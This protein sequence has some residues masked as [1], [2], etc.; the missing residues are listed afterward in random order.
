MHVLIA[1]DKFKDALSAEKVCE[2]IEK[3]IRKADPAFKTTVFPMADG[4]NGT[5]D[6]L[7]YHSKGKII[8]HEVHDPLGRIIKSRLGVS[9]D[10]K[11]AF[12]E[13]AAASGLELLKPAER[14]CVNTSTFGT[15]ELIV[16]AIALGVSRI[17]IGIGG[18]ATN[19]GGTGMAAALGYRFR[20]A[21]GE[22]LEP[23]GKN[24]LHIASIDDCDVLPGLKNI[25]ISIACD[26]SNPLYGPNGAAFAYAAQKGSTE[27]EIVMLDKGL[28]HFARLINN[29]SG[30][31]V[32][33]IPGAGAAGGLGAG[34]VAFLGASLEPGIELVMKQTHF[35]TV[36][37]E[38]DVVITGEGKIDSQTLQGKVIAGI[39]KLAN[40]YNIPV[41]ALG[42]QIDLGEQE[43]KEAGISFMT[44]IQD[45]QIPLNQ[46]IRQTSEN[47]VKTSMQ[48]IPV[49]K[50]ITEKN[51]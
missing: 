28:K 43:Q 10:G 12:I 14:H 8:S 20:D 51:Q 5:A 32:D 2:A 41:I 50:K 42:G 18:S 48:L 33:K 46:A 3:G 44:S 9:G 47:L 13:M 15:G 1:S 45:Q 35:E 36:L 11:T 30:H 24:L 19:D 7:T 16:K 34:A 25:I 6:I 39:A 22:E 26:V 27:D 31:N 29:L 17:I 21:A 49:I 40:K 37:R 23:V 4:G 38:A